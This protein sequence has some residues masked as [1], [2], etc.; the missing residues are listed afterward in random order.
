MSICRT[1]S[2]TR[3]VYFHLQEVDKTDYTSSN[4]QGVAVAA[5]IAST[6]LQGK[7]YAIISIAIGA[8]NNDA[9]L[10]GL[11]LH[12]ACV[13]D[14]GQDWQQPPAGWHTDP[15]YSQGAGK[16]LVR[17]SLIAC[18]YSLNIVNKISR[19]K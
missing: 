15:D 19:I 13:A 5:H 18:I 1:N 4:L 9:N 6:R 17:S 2:G 11:M 10:E 14:R 3:H 12:W 8:T 16:C 7:S